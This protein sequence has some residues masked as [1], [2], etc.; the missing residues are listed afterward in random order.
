MPLASVNF[1][2]RASGVTSSGE[3]SQVRI[4]P[5]RSSHVVGGASTRVTPVPS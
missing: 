1:C 5:S 3:Q 4:G 2:Y